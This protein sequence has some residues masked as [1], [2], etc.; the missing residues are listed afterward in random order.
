MGIQ[1]TV[2]FLGIILLYLTCMAENTAVC[3]DRTPSMLHE[4]QTNQDMGYVVHESF[5]MI[6]PALD[7]SFLI[8]DLF[9]K[10]VRRT[11]LYGTRHCSAGAMNKLPVTY[12]LRNTSC[13]FH[14]VMNSDPNRIP[15]ILMEARCNCN[16]GKTCIGGDINSR[17]AP[18]KYFVRAI[19]KTA[20]CGADGFYEYKHTL[21]P[22]T[23]GCTCTMEHWTYTGNLKM[24]LD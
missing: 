19:R 21:E 17:C 9:V 14:L 4:L 13:P 2:T 1:I 22:I 16:R 3:K 10:D 12:H 5:Y 11:I 6:N 15:A 20:L 7:S 23:V 8:S 24:S 18:I